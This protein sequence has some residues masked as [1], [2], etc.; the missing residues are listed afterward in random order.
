MKIDKER[1]IQLIDQLDQITKDLEEKEQV[2][3]QAIEATCSEY[4]KSARNLIHYKAI[5]TIDLRPIQK[6]LKNLGMSRLANA[7]SHVMDSLSLSRQILYCLI[8][9]SVDDEANFD[10]TTKNSEEFLINNTK[11]LLGPLSEGRR[12]RIMVTQPTEAA[13]DYPM[14]LEMVKSGMNCARINCAHDTPEIWSKIINHVKKASEATGTHVTIAMDLAGP[15]IRTG[16]IKPGFKVRKFSP[17]RNDLG[18]VV[19]PA[20][21]IFTD[22]VNEKSAPNTIP[23]AS[24]WKNQLNVGDKLLVAAD[25]RNKQRTLKVIRKT[26]DQVWAECF[27]T[28]YFRTGTVIKHESTNLNTTTV[29]EL[30]PIE[31]SILLRPDDI[32][33]IHQQ[34]V[35]GESAQIDENRNVLKPAHISCQEAKIFDKVQAGNTILFDDGK[36][37][38]IIEACKS[39]RFDV[40]ITRA[41]ETGSKLKAEKGI[42]FP[43]SDLGMSGLTEKDKK[44]LVFIA[45]HADVVNFSFVNSKE[46]VQELLNELHALNAKDR[47]SVILKIETRKAFD[48]LEEI[49][50]AA[51]QTKYI[52]VMIARGDLAVETGWE[53][54]AWV[55]REILALC[56]AAH[57]PV[58]WA[59]QVLENLA[60]KG[61]PTRSEIT[62]A[63]ESLKAECVMLN[64]GAYINDAIRLLDKILADM[65][66]FKEK[67]ETMLPK[68]ENCL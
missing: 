13:Y 25:A 67:N 34:P 31:Q 54:I 42:N 38:G 14:V 29:G 65:E 60:K 8:G 30:P 56:N 17:K 48:N 45:T 55:Q 5:R 40:R 28:L 66:N 61:L 22:Q 47:L 33:T 9:Q 52:G 23:V 53:N 43:T 64:K 24:E 3:D 63:T 1:V 11:N 15:K 68:L 12:V 10:L 26:D 35:L 36:I 18:M 7:G 39:D 62:D 41:K 46:D 58:V 44:D 21:I 37:E 20:F 6:A 51:M 16:A 49:L 57:V 2:F 4:R 19:S 59:T 27:K 50:L 32:I